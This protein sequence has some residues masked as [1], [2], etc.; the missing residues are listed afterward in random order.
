[1]FTEQTSDL[2]VNPSP[3]LET[4][5]QTLASGS[6]SSSDSSYSRSSGSTRNNNVQR[7]AGVQT[8]YSNDNREHYEQFDD[9]TQQQ[10]VAV[11]FPDNDGS[12][13]H[14]NNE[15]YVESADQLEE[16]RRKSDGNAKNSTW[17]RDHSYTFNIEV[18]GFFVI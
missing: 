14:G 8:Q 16:A 12:Q 10:M 11:E 13:L 18:V 9:D 5:S 17:S 2:I 7:V 1:M 15:K 6:S 4:A 3:S